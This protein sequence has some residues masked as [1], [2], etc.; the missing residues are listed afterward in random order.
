MSMY[1]NILSSNLEKICVVLIIHILIVT[2]YIYISTFDIYA[3]IERGND[4]PGGCSFWVLVCSYLRQSCIP[5]YWTRE[6]FG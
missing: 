5:Y 3:G 2:L 6:L 4:D 1:L